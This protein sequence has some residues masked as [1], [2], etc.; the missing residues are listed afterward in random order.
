M[1]ITVILSTR[2]LLFMQLAVILL[3]SADGWVVAVSLFF[4][5]EGGKS[6]LC[7]TWCW[8]ISSGGDLRESATENIQLPRL[9]C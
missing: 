1:N 7:R 4:M 3:G 2:D 5:G 6:G 9:M 8:I